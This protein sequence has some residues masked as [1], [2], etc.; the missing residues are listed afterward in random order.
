[1]VEA[2]DHSAW[3]QQV[4][5]VD[6]YCLLPFLPTPGPPCPPF[7]VP[8]PD[9]TPSPGVLLREASGPGVLQSPEDHPHL[10]QP[11]FQLVVQQD[12]KTKDLKTGTCTSAQIVGETGAVVVAKNRMG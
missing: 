8:P 9:C 7:S 10:Q 6:A 5:S 2:R 11:G 3:T 4:K 1:M 12:V